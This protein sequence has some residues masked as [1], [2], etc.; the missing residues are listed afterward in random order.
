M[1][2]MYRG[3]KKFGEKYCNF[4]FDIINGMIGKIGFN[5]HSFVTFYT[6]EQLY[7]FSFY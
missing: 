3:Q 1:L 4:L 2:R 7:L 6:D 5:Q